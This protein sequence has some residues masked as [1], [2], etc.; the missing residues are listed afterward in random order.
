MLKA[1]EN[2]GEVKQH[3]ESRAKREKHY[4]EIKIGDGVRVLRSRKRVGGKR[5]NTSL[6]KANS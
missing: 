1:L 5:G 6:D 2:R 4:A 3:M